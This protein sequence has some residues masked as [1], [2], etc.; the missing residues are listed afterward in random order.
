MRV[1]L[2]TVFA[3]G[4]GGGDS[5]LSRSEPPTGV[6]GEPP[7][8]VTSSGSAP[9][10]E[11]TPPAPAKRRD[12]LAAIEL[13]E[14]NH[15][16]STGQ[17]LGEGYK[18]GPVLTTTQPYANLMFNTGVDASGTNLTSLVPLVEGT[19]T[20]TQVETMSSSLANLV[21]KLAREEVFVDAPPGQR[22][23]DLLVSVHAYSG[24]G[25]AQLAKGSA[26][27]AMGIAQATAA[28]NLARASGKSYAIRAVTTVHGETDH[29]LANAGYQADLLAWQKDYESDAKALSGQHEAVPLFETQMSSWTRYGDATSIIP[30]QQLGAHVAAP[31]KVILVGPKYHYPYA[32]GVH[33]T[34]EGY[35]HMGE[36]YAKAY[37]RV[38]LEGGTWEPVRPKQ[39]TRDGAVITVAFHVPSP[40]LAFD[41]S[42]VSDPGNLG[43]EYADDGPTT[44]TI[45][46]V[47]L[48]GVDTVQIT[49]SDVPT[50]PN[51]RL[52]YAF[53][54][55][56]NAYA[57][58]QTGPR[59]NLR[60][61]DATVSLHGCVLY[62][63]CIHFD[64]AVP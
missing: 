27:Y 38:V 2:L 46:Q 41:T 48:V 14:V 8:A 57:G 39:I 25:Y 53:T 49:L 17:S 4:N 52:R 36:D 60:D 28:R 13:K 23:H 51:P 42:R 1:S 31:G 35:R 61:S 32:D 58:P 11:T 10:P 59:G 16:L 24:Y 12:P 15:I 64:E 30:A 40:P 19:P 55:T 34:N 33:L 63:W 22:S 20:H 9:V 54:G 56:P 6:T 18:G 37:R 62:N 3:C 5:P 43:F 44:P 45:V 29:T 21:T 26:Q 7:P 47:A 50:S